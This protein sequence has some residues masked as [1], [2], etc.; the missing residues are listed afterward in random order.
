MKIGELAEITGLAPSRIRFYER[1]GIISAPPR[2]AN[3]YRKYPDTTL[4]ALQIIVL[5]QQVGFSLDEL[6]GM[7]PRDESGWSHDDLLTVLQRKLKDLERLEQRLKE[8]KSALKNMI[9]DIKNKPG[10][11]SCKENASRILGRLKN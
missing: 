3:G 11:L 9:R 5:G 6:A 8:N 2:S 7:L 10:G 4:Q 1:K